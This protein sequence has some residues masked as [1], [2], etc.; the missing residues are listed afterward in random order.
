MIANTIDTHTRM[1]LCLGMASLRRSEDRGGGGGEVEVRG[2]EED[3]NTFA[4]YSQQYATTRSL[5]RYSLYRGTNTRPWSASPPP[6]C[7]PRFYARCNSNAAV[8]LP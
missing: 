1:P 3:L 6:L 8:R 5:L 7:M 4:P 2:G